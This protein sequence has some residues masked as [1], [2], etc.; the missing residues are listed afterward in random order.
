LNSVNSIVWM[1]D[2]VAVSAQSLGEI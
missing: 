1:D 2:K